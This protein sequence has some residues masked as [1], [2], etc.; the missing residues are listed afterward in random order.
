MQIWKRVEPTNIT[1]VGWRTIVTK[2]FV[3]PDGKTE[4]FDTFGSEG[5]E[6]VAIIALT[7]ENKVVIARQFRFGPEKIMDELPGGFVDKNE[8][9]EAAIRRE[10]LEETGFTV[11]TLEYLGA[12]NKDTYMNAKWH[13]FFG[14]NCVLQQAQKLEPEEHIEID[15]ISISNFIDNAK[16]NRMTD[17]PAVLMAYDKLVELSRN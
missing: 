14:T 16:N 7:T 2:T 13:V 6:F 12:F 10:L 3:M 11:G 5:Q 15:C 9:P 1:K 4:T 17:V 8:D